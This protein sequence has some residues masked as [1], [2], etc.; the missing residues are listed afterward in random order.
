MTENKDIAIAEEMPVNDL[1]PARTYAI[2]E[3]AKPE[4]NT[5]CSVNPELGADAK[6]L[7]YNASNNPTHKIDDFI[8]KQIALKDLFVVLIDDKGESYQCVSN[9]VWGSLKKMFA[10]YGAPTYEEPINVVVKQ[11]KVKRGTM[12]TLEV[13]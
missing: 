10:V 11:V 4:D 2:A 6:K 5:F 1:A 8:N 12:L 3:L 9:G 7:I 13:A